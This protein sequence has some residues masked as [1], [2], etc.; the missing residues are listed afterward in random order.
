MPK[1]SAIC[2]VASR[3]KTMFAISIHTVCHVD[4]QARVGFSIK[5]LKFG[6]S[7]VLF[8]R[9]TDYA[10]EHG[11]ALLSKRFRRGNIEF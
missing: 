11:D 10:G 4:L 5:L 8:L 9:R 7:G 2:E 3:R 1:N 6:K